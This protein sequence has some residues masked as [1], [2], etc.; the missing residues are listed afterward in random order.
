MSAVEQQIHRDQARA[1]SGRV[2]AARSDAQTGAAPDRADAPV[3]YVIL[4]YNEARNIRDCL[5]S[6]PAGA[7]AHVL[8][9]GS[10][11]GT[12][13]LARE[14]GA[15]VHVNP[16]ESFGRQR[17]WA[18]DHIDTRHDWQMHLDADERMTA[19]LAREM[20][21]RLR[22]DPAEGGFFV[23]SKLMF[24][25][26]WLR[27]AGDYPT[28]QVRLFHRQRLRFIDVGHG[29]REQTDLPV[30]KLAE[31]Y[32]HLAFSH[33]LEAW[34]IKHAGYARREAIEAVANRR[35]ES[36]GQVLRGLFGD[37]IQR[38]RSCKKLAARLPCRRTQRLLYHLVLKRAFLDGWA[39]LVYANM[40]ATYESMISL[41][42]ALIR[43]DVE[44]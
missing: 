42:E 31:P 5:A 26:K 18:I 13:D 22:G 14:M 19:D 36:T 3:S 40:M 28:Y 4:T 6:L 15:Q 11:D 27:H 8:D 9:S 24:A 7:D 37:A 44:P 1:G 43:R 12:A 30:G 29:Q 38:R 10:T 34:L 25:G 17:N 16:F 33:G 23:P 21:E 39:G 35:A 32:L 20:A 41:H 2:V